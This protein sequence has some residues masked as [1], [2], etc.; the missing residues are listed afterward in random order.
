MKRLLLLV[1]CS[2]VTAAPPIVVPR[3]DG[4]PQTALY[5]HGKAMFR[6][7]H[8]G[9]AAMTTE[10]S[11]KL[12]RPAASIALRLYVGRQNLATPADAVIQT[13]AEGRFDAWLKPDTYCLVVGTRSREAGSLPAPPESLAGHPSTPECL[14]ALESTCDGELIVGERQT[15]VWADL[16]GKSCVWNS[17]CA[18]KNV[19]VAAPIVPAVVPPRSP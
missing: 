19:P 1:V 18:E 7:A 6:D 13:D 9:G 3:P 11:A 16:V 8:C 15:D 5:V 2:C 17:P 4:V 14:K 10:A 12:R